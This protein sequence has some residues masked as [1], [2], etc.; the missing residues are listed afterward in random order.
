MGAQNGAPRA[1]LCDVDGVL[2]L[3][4]PGAMTGADLAHGL[5]EGTLAGTAFHPD[6][7]LPAITGQVTDEEWREG[8][9]A[10]LADLCGGPDRGRSLVAAWT[11]VPGTVDHEVAELLTAARDHVPVVLVSNATTRLESDL[12][13]LGLADLAAD[14]VN[15]SRVG[16]AKPDPR[17]YRIAAERAGA[18]PGECAF[19]DD[20]ATNVAAA[21]ELGMAGV[22]HRGPADLRAALERWGL[23]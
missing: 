5:P 13:A 19:V 6:H 2:R 17:V 23:A 9:A 1:L 16:V 10:A 8:I 11:N 3:W 12:A 18:A 14:A 22:H 21:R 20:S 7:L 15:T 4:P